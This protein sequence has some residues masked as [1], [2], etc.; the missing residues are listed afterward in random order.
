MAHTQY[1]ALWQLVQK[2]SRFLSITLAG[3]LVLQPALEQP[4]AAQALTQQVIGCAEGF[5]IGAPPVV[6][7]PVAM[8]SLKTVGNPVLPG[9]ATGA[10]R[11]DLVDFIANQTAAIQLGKALFW[12]MQVGSDNKTACASCHFQAGGD[13]RATGQVN[14]GANGSF[15][16]QSTATTYAG[17]DFPFSTPSTDKNDNAAGSQGVRKANFTGITVAG[18]GTAT[19]VSTNVSDATFGN[20]RQTTGMNAPTT[21]N[22]VFNHRNF[23]NGRAQNEF[24]GVNP[25]GDRDTNAK[26]FQAISTSTY[27]TPRIRIVNASLASQAVGPVLN[28]VEMSAAGRTFPDVGRKLLG[29]K[30]LGL[31]TVNTRDSVLG[32][33]AETK[34]KGLKTTYRTLIQTAFQPKWWNGPSVPVTNAGVTRQFSMMEANFS[35]FFGLAVMLYEATLVANDSPMD[36]FLD[37]RTF[38][39]TGA[40]KTE[41]IT[42]KL[43]AVASRMQTEYGYTGGAAGIL[44]GLRLFEAPLAPAPAPNGRECIACHLGAPTTSATINNIVE[45][46]G[47]PAA[48]AFQLAGF[49]L[50]MERMFM[51]I[52]PVKTD[53]LGLIQNGTAKFGTTE[54]AYDPTAMDPPNGPAPADYKL[55]GTK[56]KDFVTNV[57]TGVLAPSTGIAVYD[58]GFYN[59]GL[60][61]TTEDPGVGGTDPFGLPLS[62]VNFLQATASTPP[63]VPGGTLGCIAPTYSPADPPVLR[64]ALGVPLFP[65]QALNS[66]GFPLLSGPIKRT[67]TTDSTGSFKTS[68]LRNLELNGPY[69]HNGGKSTLKQVIQLYDAGGDAPKSGS[70]ERGA[71]FPV[72]RR[73][74]LM[75]FYEFLDTN[76]LGMST[77]DLDDLV[78]FLIALTDD[79][80]R[81][82]K[83][84]FDHPELVLPAGNSETTIPA[85]GAA[86][87]TTALKPF[88]NLNPFVG[89]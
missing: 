69:F 6:V 56:E 50:R 51:D 18:N 16:G 58:A 79:R 13:T 15:D 71:N 81:F 78:A 76:S 2:T 41:G 32:K 59:V 53:I 10:V 4:A 28:T 12:E 19:E 7:P 43:N 70:A 89:N 8:K 77:Q 84:P 39:A 52:P 27:I 75:K 86:G 33:L 25:F 83:A 20:S 9:G 23:F 49:D 11:A 42:S 65:N 72:D 67:E 68:S 34:I 47:E 64:D 40:V 14:P 1:S 38:T 73:S 54:I 22:A 26:V 61:P 82:E 5:D 31:Q 45:G 88:L 87:R 85:V 57:E 46:Q 44:R 80:V 55:W 29:S 35:L 62:F 66:D 21:I 17:T 48:G 63:K 60:R 36:Q 30:P 24:N 3:S 37:G 74:P